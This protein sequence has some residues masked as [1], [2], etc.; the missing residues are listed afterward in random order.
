LDNNKKSADEVLDMEIVQENLNFAQDG[1]VQPYKTKND[2]SSPSSETIQRLRALAER[3]A[4]SLG[5]THSETECGSFRSTSKADRLQQ[6][7]MKVSNRSG[8]I[9]SDC[10]K[11]L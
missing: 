7:Y 5:D 11:Y 9:T 1:S 10:D 4:A 8:P 6:I 2:A 3:D